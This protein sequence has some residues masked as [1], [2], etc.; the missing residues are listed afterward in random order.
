M[1]RRLNK[2]LSVHQRLAYGVKY[3]ELEG[4]DVVKVAPALKMI[5]LGSG[6]KSSSNYLTLGKLLSTTQDS[7]L[8]Y[9][10]R[11]GCL[12]VALWQYLR[13]R[14]QEVPK[15]RTIIIYLFLEILFQV[16][17][18][19]SWPHIRLNMA[20]IKTAIPQVSPRY[21]DLINQQLSYW[22]Q[23]FPGDFMCS[24]SYDIGFFFSISHLSLYT[25]VSLFVKHK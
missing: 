11:L 20:F 24:V 12:Q 3:N 9:V 22:N 16:R 18:P 5:Y 1:T 19:Q 6:S 14:N 21:S 23:S 17:V 10:S 8:Q 25:L 15:R 13:C 2:S 7:Q 4:F